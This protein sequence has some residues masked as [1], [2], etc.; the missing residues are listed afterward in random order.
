MRPSPRHARRMPAAQRRAGRETGRSASA[1]S[2]RCRSDRADRG[3]A[4]ARQHGV[5]AAPQLAALGRARRA[6]SRT[7]SPPG[8]CTA[9]TTASTPSATPCSPATGAGWPPSSPPVPAR[10][11]ATPRAAA[12]WELRRSDA[13]DR[14]RQRPRPRGPRQA[15]GAADPPPARRSAP[16]SSPPTTASPSPHPPARILDLAA[17]LQHSRLE[18]DPRPG[19][20]PR[21][22]RLPRPRRPGPSP[23]RPHGAK[24]AQTGARQPP[25]RHH[26]H[27][28]RARGALLRALRR[29]RPP[30]PEGQRARRR[31]RR[32]TS[33]S[34]TQRLIVETG[35]LAVPPHA[36]GVRARPDAATRC[37]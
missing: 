18:R 13:R 11:S 24:Q 28:K 27:A 15:A 4:R 14:R 21:A 26:A 12:L 32:S 6:P 31:A 33:S 30:A 3:A 34:P 22:H 9:S 23:P 10:R 1:K 2:P 16:P 7:V 29:A 36:P 35:Q 8:G 5:V 37:S 17:T 25:G 20:D 19:R